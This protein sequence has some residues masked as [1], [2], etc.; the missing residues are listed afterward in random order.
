MS[1]SS[2]EP[3]NHSCAMDYCFLR[4]LVRYLLLE[5]LLCCVRFIGNSASS[6]KR[7][8]HGQL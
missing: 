2:I 3:E 1:T 7:V 4:N 5:L 8:V 6:G